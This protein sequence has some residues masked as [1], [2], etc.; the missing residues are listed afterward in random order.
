M[1]KIARLSL[2]AGAAAAVIGGAVVAAPSMAAGP[3]GGGC[4][5]SGTATFGDGDPTTPDGVGNPSG[6]FVYSFAG[7]LTHC[8]SSAAQ[9]KDVDGA[10]S[11]GRTF[12]YNGVEYQPVDQ[13]TGTG[14]CTTG[15]TGGTAAVTWADGS[16]TFIKYSTTSV[17]AGVSLSGTVLDGAD[18]VPVGGT[19]P[20]HIPTTKYT[21]A[22]TAQGVLAFEVTDPTQ[23]APGGATVQ[24]AGIDGATGL[25]HYTS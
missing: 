2:V 12:T 3:G 17:A 7:K 10:I 20:V 11:A 23:C 22:D 21:S 16:I 18:A 14:D 13:P 19:T 6:S 15:T 4:E 8:L 25:G 9:G 1:R 5:L 24:E